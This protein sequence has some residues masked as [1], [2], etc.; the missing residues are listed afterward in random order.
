MKKVISSRK[1][2]LTVAMAAIAMLFM[3][4]VVDDAA[5]QSIKDDDA[6]VYLPGLDVSTSDAML[7]GNGFNNYVV[8]ASFEPGTFDPGTNL[9]G[10]LAYVYSPVLQ[11]TLECRDAR[12]IVYN[13]GSARM[14]CIYR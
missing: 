2:Y 3:I 6:S 9:V 10:V 13:D 8:R 5:A 12:I 14:I 1:S 7:V 11:N 4:A